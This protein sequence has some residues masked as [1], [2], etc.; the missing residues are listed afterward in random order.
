MSLREQ[1]AQVGGV[2]LLCKGASEEIMQKSGISRSNTDNF[3]KVLDDIMN[4]AENV[5]LTE[6]AQ[7]NLAKEQP[8]NL[9][10]N[11]KLPRG[12]ADYD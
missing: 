4:G 11:G 3:G 10:N 12:R 7:K 8:S 1:F 2:H 6:T 5:R 9:N